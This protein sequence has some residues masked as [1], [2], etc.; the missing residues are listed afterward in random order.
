MK[1]LEVMVYLLLSLWIVVTYTAREKNERRLQAFRQNMLKDDERI[2]DF[3]QQCESEDERRHARHKTIQMVLS[4]QRRCRSPLS[5]AYT[6]TNR[7]WEN[8]VLGFTNAQ[9]VEHFRI[10]E[11]TCATNCVQ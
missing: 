5:W 7:W 1:D 6:R 9:W 11:E 8:Y 4:S 3:I 10:S 2:L